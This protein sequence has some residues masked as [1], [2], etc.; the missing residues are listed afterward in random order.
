VNAVAEM[1]SSEVAKAVQQFKLNARW[2]Q[3]RPH[4]AQMAYMASPH[5]FN[6]IPAGR[7]SGKTENFKRKLVMR[8]MTAMTPWTPRFFERPYARD[9]GRDAE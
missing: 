9:V 1:A 8:A 2:T 6:V 5:R 3:L 4:P 7:R